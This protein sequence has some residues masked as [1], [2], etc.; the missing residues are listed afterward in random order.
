M[1]GPT[2]RPRAWLARL[3]LIA[4]ALLAALMLARLTSGDP[5]RI[6]SA[7]IG[8][9]APSLTLPGLDGAPRLADA[10]LRAGHP[11]IINIFGSWCVPCRVE[12]PHLMALAADPKMRA[13]GAKLLGVAQKDTPEAIK[14]Y[15]GE[16]GDPYA[17]IGLDADNR[18]GID[19][20]VYGVPETFIVDGAGIIVAKHVGPLGEG[21]LEKEILPALEKAGKAGK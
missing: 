2:A 1:S 15:L 7:L 5:A 16:L 19:W 9:P 17:A 12:H 6:P 13:L 18:A 21:D 11:T 10:D 4:V 8:K 14:K 3:P 20:G